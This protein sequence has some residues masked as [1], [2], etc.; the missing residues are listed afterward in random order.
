MGAAGGGAKRGDDRRQ[1]GGGPIAEE[2]EGDVQVRTADDESAAAQ[3]SLLPGDEG[4][5]RLVVE[6]ECAEEPKPIHCR[7]TLARNV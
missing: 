4:V 6:A 1:L 2:G 7:P 3:L 5:D